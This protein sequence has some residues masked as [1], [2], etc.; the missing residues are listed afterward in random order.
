MVLLYNFII[1]LIFSDDAFT[2]LFLT[3]TQK[4]NYRYSAPRLIISEYATPYD[5]IPY[6]FSLKR[7][8]YQ[9]R[10]ILMLSSAKEYQS[11]IF[12]CLR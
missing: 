11:S 7:I 6:L 10:F 1:L 2:Q 8:C 4:E 3:K 5:K 9:R 12:D